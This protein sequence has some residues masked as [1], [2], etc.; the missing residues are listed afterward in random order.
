MTGE[1]WCGQQRH[2]HPTEVCQEAYLMVG[3]DGLTLAYNDTT[4]LPELAVL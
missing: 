3:A 1:A 4:I 2:G